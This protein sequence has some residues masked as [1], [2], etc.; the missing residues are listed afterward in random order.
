MN[1]L[2]ILLLLFYTQ[3]LIAQLSLPYLN[4]FDNPSSDEGW[5]HYA[6]SGSDNWERGHLIADPIDTD[7][8]WNTKLNETPDKDSVMILESPAYNLTDAGLPY[9]LSFKYKSYFTSG[10]LVLEYTL[11][12]GSTW[13]LLDPSDVSKKN[14]RFSSKGVDYRDAAIDISFLAGNINVKFRFKFTTYSLVSGSGFTINDFAI[15]PEY[16]NIY[17]SQGEPVEISPLCTNF[18]VLTSLNFDNQ[19]AD[20]FK[21]ETNYYLSDDTELDDSDT[22]LI[23]HTSNEYTTDLT[24]DVEIPTPSGLTPGQYYIVYKYDYTNILEEDNENDNIGY[25][26]LLV[27]P[28]YTL[29]YNTDFESEDINWTVDRNNVS[30]ISIWERGVGTRHHIEGTHSGNYALHTSN[31]VNEHPDYTFQ[32]VE[33]PYFNFTSEVNPIILSFWYK[34][35]DKNKGL[36]KVQYSSDCST[37]WQ[38]LSVIPENTT[39][40]WEYLNILLDDEISANENVKFRITYLNHYTN[41]EGIIFDD[42]YLGTEK[43]DLTIESVFSNDRFTSSNNT[44]DVLTYQLRN[45]GTDLLQNV[46]TNFYWSANNILDDNDVFLGSKNISSLEA[47]NTGE[48]LEFIYNKPTVITGDYFIIYEIDAEND[49]EEI[50]ENNNIGFIPIEQISTVGFPYFNDFE[51]DIIGWKHNSTLGTDDWELTNPQGEVLNEAFSG[52]KAFVTN[53]SGSASSMSRMHLYTPVFDLSTSVN[54]VLEFDMILD[55]YMLCYCFEFTM[56]ISYSIDNGATW[57]ALNPVNESFSKW[58]DVLEYN[59][60]NGTDVYNGTPYS[61]VLFEKRELALAGYSAYN[62]RDIDRNTKY[63]LNIPQLKD[64]TNIRFRFN[65]GTLNNDDSSANV[66]NHD[67]VEGALIDNFQIREGEVDLI[68]PYQKNLHL[69]SVAKKLN[70]SIDVK[71]T[72]NHISNTSNIKFYLS[73]DETYDSSDYLIGTETLIGIKPDRKEHLLL[74]YNL[75]GSLSNYNNLVYVIDDENVVDEISE[76]NNIGAWSLGLGG[77]SQFPYS[78]NF[79]ADIIDGWNG[80]A[81]NNYYSTE[82]T[83]Y[84]VTNRLALTARES[85]ENSLY[86]GILRT[87]QVPYGSWQISYTPLYYIVT[88]TFDLTVSDTS[89]PLFMSFDLMS[90]GSSYENGANMEYSLD[91]GATWNILTENLSTTSSNWYSNQDL[92]DKMN[93]E[94]GWFE[95]NGE[96]KEV[97]MD[98]SFL[99]N[100]NNVTFRYK[101]FSNYATASTRPR[102][103]RLDNF[104]IG[105][106]ITLNVDEHDTFSYFKYFPNPVTNELIILSN[107]MSLQSLEVFSASGQL[108]STTESHLTRY[109]LNFTSYASGIYFVK[110][111]FNKGSKTFKIVK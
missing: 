67:K 38:D 37:S 55:N 11:D 19:Y 97:E 36:Y 104:F 52:E 64:E 59:D 85:E 8:I 78:E 20:F 86:D 74:E 106:K 61:D 94:P 98:I 6:I 62:S 90:I 108:L 9:A 21:I 65:V 92:M 54:P 96:I 110:V 77:I 45:S 89:R 93:D 25:A 80:Y 27:K 48:W 15:I 63:I 32:S 49:V 41:P 53:A 66:S 88:P 18:E 51:G 46:T 28:I 12:N 17:A 5:T 105:D 102:G 13:I 4:N 75:P 68:V 82:L 34:M 40:D 84:R 43:P 7:L 72:G 22:F 76:E 50:R 56:N 60:L 103:F 31:S 79:E 101:Y 100:Q 30:E 111:T 71:N 47:N 91:G 1:K 2:Y 10:N 73:Q 99:Q 3:L 109:A 29:P 81:Y 24:Y 35:V 16:Y 39:D 14:W 107:S 95:N 87:E 26:S 58:N 70:F 44:T 33:S 69:S 83:K 42:F 57:L 23:T